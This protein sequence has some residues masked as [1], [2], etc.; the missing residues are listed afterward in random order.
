MHIHIKLVLS[1][2]WRHLKSYYAFWLYEQFL[3]VSKHLG[4][5]QTNT[6]DLHLTWCVH[7]WL[8]KGSDALTTRSRNNLGQH[9]VTEALRRV[10]SDDEQCYVVPVNSRLLWY[11]QDA[12]S[13]EQRS[14]VEGPVIIL[15]WL[16]YLLDVQ[17]AKSHDYSKRREHFSK[18]HV[19]VA[20]ECLAE[21]KD[22][23]S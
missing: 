15:S 13:F 20:L 22:A 17:V 7:P 2:R 10:G 3:W 23:L 14:T 8:W 4:N 5:K 6:F 18:Q 19:P 11:F 1:N 9:V 21:L 12:V 16:Y